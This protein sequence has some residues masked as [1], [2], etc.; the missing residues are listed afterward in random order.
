M[1]PAYLLDTDWVISYLSGHPE[2]VAKVENLRTTGLAVSI[3][4]L[5]ELYE[6]VYYSTNP[7]GN[8]RALHDFLA[9]VEIIGVD[10]AI[11]PSQRVHP[12]NQ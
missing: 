2:I 5:A 8:E 1:S 11:C 3:I 9:D 7:E 6:G 10:E 12:P 4:S